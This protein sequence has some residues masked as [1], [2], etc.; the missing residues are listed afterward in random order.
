MT[1][2]LSILFFTLGLSLLSMLFSLS[3]GSTSIPLDQLLFSKNIEAHTIFF[4]LR[5]P[6]T[7]TAFVSGSLLALAGLLMQLLL[8]NPL[9][10]PYILGISSGAALMTLLFMLLGVATHWLFM[11]SWIGSFIVMFFMLSLSKK[12]QW[13][14]Q[15]LL[16]LGIALAYGFSAAMSF[17]ILLMKD[18][19]LH[20]MLFWLSGDLNGATFPYLGLSVLILGFSVCLYLAP[21]FNLLARGELS[22]TTLGLSTRYYRFLIYFLSAL[23]TATA[24]SLSGCIGFIGLIVPHFTRLIAGYD[25]RFVVPLA[26]L[27]GG[28]LLMIADTFAR[29][30]FAPQQIPV[31]IIMA[32]I[33]VPLFVA[34]LRK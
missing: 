34:L 6:R 29:T 1:S 14:T 30:L 23:F 17:L 12:H 16:L 7:L 28:S 9:A 33:G 19:N 20:N 32:L 22:A 8:E 4:S 15:T 26:T 10:D 31:G 25:H 24:V 27:F 5:L 13:R 18:V 11:G 3:K 2:R 21:I